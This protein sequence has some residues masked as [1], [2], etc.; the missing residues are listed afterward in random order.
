M[1]ITNSGLSRWILGTRPAN[2]KWNNNIIYIMNISNNNISIIFF[3]KQMHSRYLLK[4]QNTCTWSP[5]FNICIENSVLKILNMQMKCLIC[6]PKIG[7]GL[8]CTNICYLI[9][10]EVATHF[11]I[12]HHLWVHH[13]RETGIPRLTLL[14]HHERSAFFQYLPV[15]MSAHLARNLSPF[16][17]TAAVAASSRIGNRYSSWQIFIDLQQYISSGST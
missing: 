2:T 1:T 3:F 16:L 15:M 17:Q 12:F 9:V 5:K 14:I 11:T 7:W 10:K 8:F 4:S 6:C 13:L